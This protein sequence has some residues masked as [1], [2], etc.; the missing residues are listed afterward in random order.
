MSVDLFSFIERF[1]RCA[2]LSTGKQVAQ[3]CLH[4]VVEEGYCGKLRH[5][6]RNIC[7]QIQ[8]LA[9]SQAFGL[10]TACTVTVSFILVTHF[11]Y[12]MLVSVVYIGHKYLGLWSDV[13]LLIAWRRQDIFNQPLS[14]LGLYLTGIQMLSHTL[15]HI[16][17]IP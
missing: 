11:Q 16:F 17:A 3:G 13:H 2:E 8:V 15:E 4:T 1:P 5:I 6:I 14:K 7:L 9:C 12:R 10:S